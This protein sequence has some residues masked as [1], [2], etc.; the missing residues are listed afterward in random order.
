[1][2]LDRRSF[3]A[4]TATLAATAAG[5]CTG[6]AASPTA[7][8]R[9]TAED[10]A[11]LAREA[12][13]VFGDGGDGGD[14]GEADPNPRGGLAVRVVEAGPVTTEDT[15]VP[16]PTGRPVVV[17]DGVYRFA[18]EPV[19]SRELRSFSVTINPLRVDEGAE[20][21]GPGDRIR[22]E[23][24]PAVDRRKFR[25]LGFVDERPFG[26]GTSLSYRPEAVEESV[27]VP[28]PEYSVIV[29]PDG[30]ARFEVD[31]G[32]SYT[33]YTYELTADR[34]TSATAFGADVRERFGFSLAVLP[35][36]EREILDAAIDPETPAPDGDDYSGYHVA[37]DQEPSDALRSLVNRFRERE[38]VVF[39]W[40]RRPEPWRASGE[41]V[42]RYDG[43]VY[44]A[45]LWVEESAFTETPTPGA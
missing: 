9:L 7:S 23:E 38:P 42:V 33:V 14:G 37:S 2:S 20:T 31:G 27:L 39:E 29:W 16:L 22:F 41:Y 15:D 43:A 40:E 18:A 5:G 17:N 13:T 25:E 11:G 6:C 24:L 8:L 28:E 1:M 19:D 32:G 35:R 26:I 12:L 45:S 3:L 36:E 30:P 4:T 21:P 34:V 10:D 44:W